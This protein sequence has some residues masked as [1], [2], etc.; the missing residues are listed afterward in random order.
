MTDS[1]SGL[2][3]MEQALELAGRA[4]NEDEV[5]VG[6]VVVHEGKVIGTGY[7]LRETRQ[8]PTAHAEVIALQ[9]AATAIGSWRLID[10]DLYVTL[11]PCVMCLGACSLGRVRKVIYAAQDP[12]G[13]AIS[14]GYSIPGDVRLNHRFEV[15]YQPHPRARE[16]LQDFFR[17]RR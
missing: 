1:D 3:Y 4:A 2:S 11:E 13:G 10:C 16:L 6:A 12:K 15:D 14:L 9:A 7:N 17:K 8:D 5:P